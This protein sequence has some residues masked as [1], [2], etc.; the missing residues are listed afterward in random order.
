M[1]KTTRIPILNHFTPKH[2][3][4]VEGCWRSIT[5]REDGQFGETDVWDYY[6]TF[7]EGL[8]YKIDA[9]DIGNWQHDI[10]YDEENPGDEDEIETHFIWRF[11]FCTPYIE[12]REEVAADIQSYQKYPWK[13]RFD[14]IRRGSTFSVPHLLDDSVDTCVLDDSVDK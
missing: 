9:D 3:Y 14:A 11:M 2:A 7:R 8:L 1:E 5:L 13:Y 6:D 4:Y 10:E 12:I